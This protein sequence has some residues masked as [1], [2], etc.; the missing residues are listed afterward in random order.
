VTVRY[1][2]TLVGISWVVLQPLL[3]M[4]IYTVFFSHLAK[5]PSA[6][7]PY[8]L[9]IFCGFLPWHLFANG[10]ADCGNSLVA[11]QHLITK[12]YFP[13]LVIPIAAV[14]PR[15]VDLACAFL[16]LVGMMAYFGVSPT[17]NLSALPLFIV[18]AAATSI[19][20]GLWLSALNVHYRDV[21]HLVPFVTQ[22]WFFLSPVAYPTSLVPDRWTHLYGLNPMVAVV[23]GFRWSVL[24]RGEV[25]LT[26]LGISGA[27]VIFILVSGLYFFRA[28]E[29]SLADIV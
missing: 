17:W 3:M 29:K 28:T 22:V 7:F 5:V 19:G 11:N 18:L 10:L 16:V 1:R 23:E 27:V 15:L 25:A 21:R 26:T 2:Q 12:V 6:G 9:F 14:M 24:G 8:P 20:V 4:A 13:R